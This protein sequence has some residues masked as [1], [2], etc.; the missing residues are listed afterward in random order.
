MPKGLRKIHFTFDAKGLTRH[1]GLLLFHQFFKSLR[2]RHFLQL[3]VSWPDYHHR[4]FHPVDLFLAHLFAIVT[5]IGRI[6]NTQT[7]IHNGV[8]P[9]VLG[10]T[11]FPRQDTLRRFLWRFQKR[12]LQSL[13]A[14]HDKLRAKLFQRLGLLYSATIDADTTSLTT[15]GHQEGV[16]VGYL[17]KRRHGQPSYAPLLASE[18]R[19]GLS[20]G[21]ELRAGNIGGSTGAWVFLRN[22][23]NKLP[24]TLASSRIR[25]RL[26]GGF[27]DKDLVLPLDKEGLGYVVSAH[28]TR[29]LRER[30][31]SARY[32]AF[33]QGW[34]AGEFIYTPFHWNKPHRFVAI[35][36][37]KALEPENIQKHL[38]TFQDH[39]YHQA[40]VTNLGLTPEAVYRFYCDRAFQELLIREFKD[41]FSMAQ[42]PTRSFFANATYM[43]MILWAYDLV[44]AFQFLCLPEEVRRWNISTL[45]RELWW[46]PAEWVNHGG[47]N[48][49][50]LPKKYP[51]QDTVRKIQGS[52]LSVRA[53]I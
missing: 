33:A 28:M 3:H 35:R 21:M 34:E 49:L 45:R 9:P 8:I 47:Q 37:P 48:R 14:A 1:G 51:Q 52:T 17:P 31:C 12:H 29:P 26:D 18:G 13:E 19:T 30:M 11:D 16:A 7:L 36:K 38:F 24:S 10:L 32:H 50:R 39:T 43:E 40:L 2:L 5:G 23:L 6:A 53:L 42:I 20:L 27:Y 15:Y 25:L 44:L 4:A 41:S 46:L 22:I